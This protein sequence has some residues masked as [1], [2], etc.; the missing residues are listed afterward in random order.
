MTHTRDDG[1]PRQGVSAGSDTYAA[2]HRTIDGHLGRPVIPLQR[3][4]RRRGRLRAF[5]S[6]TFTDL[7][8]CREQVRKALQRLGVEDVAMETNT[9]E[10]ARPVDL[11]LAD[12]RS[13]D[14]YIGLF[15]WRYGFIPEGHQ[16]SITELEYRAAGAAG[17]PRLIFLLREDAPWPPTLMDLGNPAQDRIRALR[18][19][20]AT[21][22]VCEFFS[23][24]QDLR[25]AVS[26]AVSRW[27]QS[28]VRGADAELGVTAATVTAWDA[29]KRRLTEQYRRLD[30]DALTPPDREEYLQ[31]QLREVFVE[32]TV[33]ED[34][35]PAEL[36]KELQRK[37]QDAAELSSADVPKGMDRQDLEDARRTYRARPAT[38]A[39]DVLTSVAQRACVLLGDPGAGKSTLARYVSLALIDERPGDRLEPLHGYQPVLVELRE[40]ALHRQKYE[41][42]TEYLAYRHRSDGL[43]VPAEVFDG[44][45]THGGRALMI[46]DGL[47]ELF[48]Q[49]EREAISLQIAGFAAAYPQVRIL[50]T[51]RIIGYRPRV[52][53]DAGFGLY[54][55][56][57]L[58]PRQVDAFL[59]SWY[60]LALHDRP[61]MAAERRQRLAS[62]ISESPPIRE[63]AGNPLLLTI[64]AIIG[65]HQELPRERWKV[66]DHAASV[67]VQHWDINKHLSD[68]R[69][70]AAIIREDDKKELLRLL[71][72]RMQEGVRGL[73][74]NHLWEDDLLTEIR[75]YLRFRFQYGE[76]HATA[77][78][79][80]M[81]E[82]F[83][84]RNFVLARYGSGVYGFVHRALL[85]FFCASE[86]VFRFEK[87]REL[88]EADLTSKV[89]AAHWEDPAWAEVLRLIAGMVDATIADQLVTYLLT[90]ARPSR[91]TVL[92]RPPLGAVVLAVQ[93]L[94]EV[95]NLGAAAGSAEL[96][97]RSV[98]DLLRCPTRSF[99]DDRHG[100]RMDTILPII[101]AIGAR[102]P[103]RE[104]YLDWFR[105]Q[106]RRATL[107]PAVQHAA[108]IAAALFPDSPDIAGLLAEDAVTGASAQ[109][110]RAC[111][112]GHAAAWTD[113]PQTRQLVNR[114]LR[115]PALV[116]RRAAIEVLTTHW[117]AAS[118]TL[119]ALLVMVR[120][121]HADVRKDSLDALNVH[122]SD[123]TAT[124]PVFL[125]RAARDPSRQVR[126]A[127]VECLGSRWPDRPE[128]RTALRAACSDPAWEVR[129]AAVQAM[130]TRLTK[131]DDT[132]VAVRHALADSDEDVRAAAVEALS[133]RWSDHRDTLPMVC[134]AAE[135]IDDTVRKAAL[136]ALLARWPD[137]A[138]THAV[139]DRLTTD[140]NGEVRCTAIEAALRRQRPPDPVAAL[141][142]ETA[143]DASDDVRRSTVEA[144]A[145]SW[146][147]E[148][149][150]RS[151]F[152]HALTDPSPDVR[153]AAI[154][155]LAEHCVEH[156][157]TRTALARAVVDL[158]A[159]VREAAFRATATYW[160]DDPAL[161]GVLVRATRSDSWRLR[162]MAVESLVACW[163]T[164]PETIAALAH[165]CRDEAGIVRQ[166]AIE[167]LAADLGASPAHQAIV[168]AATRDGHHGTRI[169]AIDAMAATWTAS[170]RSRNA[171]HAA[172]RSPDAA[173][174]CTAVLTLAMRWPDQATTWRA[175][176]RCLIDGSADV[177]TVTLDILAAH[178][179]DRPE[180]VDAFLRATRDPES[181]IRGQALHALAATW[182]QH[183]G[184]EEA[185]VRAL[186][187]PHENVRQTALE[188][189]ALRTEPDDRIH[190]ALCEASRDRNWGVR[191]A[192]LD[193]LAARWDGHPGSLVAVGDASL[194][195][196]DN[197]RS[198]AL[199]ALATRWADHPDTRGRI[200]SGLRDHSSHVR[201]TCFEFLAVRWRDDAR[202]R[203]VVRRAQRDLDCDI[204]WM[205]ATA[206]EV[207]G[208]GSD[209]VVRVED[210][211]A[212][213]RH[214]NNVHRLAGLQALL[215]HWPDQ[216]EAFAAARAAV[217]DATMGLVR[218]TALHALGARWSADPESGATVLRAATHPDPDVRG[219]AVR[220]LGCWWPTH[221]EARP[222]FHR[223]VRSGTAKAAVAALQAL[224]EHL[225][226]HP[227]TFA[228]VLGAT[229][230]PQP[231]VR[232]AALRALTAW[233]H[234]HPETVNALCRAAAEAHERVRA[235]AVQTLT[236]HWSGNPHTLAV[237]RR[238][239]DDP[240][241][242]VRAA[243]RDAVARQQRGP[244]PTR[245][246]T[247]RSTR[248]PS[249]IVRFDSLTAITARWPDDPETLR[250][251]RRLSADGDAEVRHHAISV[252]AGLWSDRP[253]TLRTVQDATTD[254]DWWVRYGAVQ[255]LVR[256]W[257][258]H[259]ATFGL[260]HAA[261]TDP[262]Q[263][264]RSLAIILLATRWLD[265]AEVLPTVAAAA[266]ADANN[267]V[268]QQAVVV[269]G[270]AWPEA[271]E[272]VSAIRVATCSPR[273]YTRWVANEALTAW[274]GSAAGPHTPRLAGPAALLAAVRSR[275]HAARC[276]A[277]QE[278][279]GRFADHRDTLPALR[280]A[281]ASSCPGVRYVAMS[282]ILSAWADRVDT[283][284]YLRRATADPDPAVRRS[285]LAHLASN[286]P[287]SPTTLAALRQGA[288]DDD[289]DNRT[290]AI[291]SLLLVAPDADLATETRPPVEGEND[292][293]YGF[294]RKWLEWRGRTTATA[295]LDG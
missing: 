47:D 102:W 28:T 148:H 291:A 39:F 275:N 99:K 252:L 45:L 264:V 178:R 194:D 165:G 73:A 236:N 118:H 237:L 56:Q 192:A 107:R 204:R 228:A 82:Q 123:A 9:A 40:Y 93:C 172:L 89:Y 101:A 179:A 276:E 11:S 200:E 234:E 163:P 105:A 72:H 124:Y 249:W 61:A 38:P 290:S 262:D 125:G 7:R 34:V 98:I 225:P 84:T 155:A 202:T 292:D 130:A 21:A 120:D 261:A 270:A 240:D 85:E 174:R 3:D 4:P 187:D 281:A 20:L 139:L 81:I 215:M 294:L 180:A 70:D 256:R 186:R 219:S 86:I 251:V 146:P 121:V 112:L 52:L 216:P 87:T 167:A 17:I 62:A 238:A 144:L 1:R 257:P 51:S 220:A 141:L 114:S 54:T 211:V 133:S 135:D 31:I 43:G 218:A 195:P 42:F 273:M 217:V 271:P 282:A 158:D 226:D 129:R 77:V 25:P 154:A 199:V 188:T 272:I 50:V 55:V 100:A 109:Q 46:F 278:L 229:R 23:S 60:E 131:Q 287:Q 263:L 168:L 32:P 69:I 12:V 134:R 142:H 176:Q 201:R 79:T 113:A 106:G 80:V 266:T 196:D 248:A 184:T 210:A 285:A 162:Q 35:P 267:G 221:P 117:P 253:A 57:D 232:Q 269:L 280:R 205:A 58:D 96:V 151:A 206:P 185:L 231:D 26:E 111:L 203:E 283:P 175:V 22:H 19:E 110:R 75:N 71:A 53:R 78:A 108:R 15:A 136:G 132:Y 103:G 227:D 222:I 49:R 153:K 156:P 171:V 258:D 13:C 150:S 250:A 254:V 260:V 190:A 182:S 286:W 24:A 164:A 74:G 33:R 170:W 197:V 213:T 288:R 246:E 88:T 209:R 239:T 16:H 97:L 6:S 2:H 242:D 277:L 244:L 214:E 289:M 5:V 245:A 92:D 189:L 230:H 145:R 223:A 29:Y 64:L 157:H 274:G 76:A 128:A 115:D 149:A 27:M 279:A 241:A 293:V 198:A 259:P 173:V 243:R 94:A 208:G 8:E 143:R 159:G 152:L 90:E 41:T 181:L 65:K 14:V 104:I 284:A 177:R 147:E 247:Y 30:L 193:T 138:S 37:L 166:T 212:A 224:V 95:R 191:R 169:A 83:R 122:W 207:F 119:D 295:D 63:L 67:L 265:R 44:Y 235:D 127:A 137:H 161:R 160:A 183:R 10:E 233:W 116:V 268:G 255:V 36:S 59:G 91:S 68:A 48:D 18:S 66:Y 126:Q 140:L